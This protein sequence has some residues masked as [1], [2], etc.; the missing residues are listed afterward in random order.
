MGLAL[1]ADTT[2]DYPLGADV[3]TCLTKVQAKP[4]ARDFDEQLDAAN[5]LYGCFL[6]FEWNTQQMCAELERIADQG[7]YTMEECRRV[8]QVLHNQA[9]KYAYLMP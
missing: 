9:R 4:Y 5:A 3:E 2:Q 6:K 8:E 1:F 7:N